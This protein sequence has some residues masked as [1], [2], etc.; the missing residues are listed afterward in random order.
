MAK[1][2]RRTKLIPDGQLIVNTDDILEICNEPFS[3]PTAKIILRTDNFDRENNILKAR[4]I[5]QLPKR[6]II[7]DGATIL[8]W[9]NT[10]KTVV[11]RSS[12]DSFDPVKGFLWAYFQKTSGMSRTK[13]NKYL[14]KIQEEYEIKGEYENGRK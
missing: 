10:D 7:N 4:T 5:K 11:K 2:T 9:N 14:R 3:Y 1:I 6:Y 8:F 12:E 13:A